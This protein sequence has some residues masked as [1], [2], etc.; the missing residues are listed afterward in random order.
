MSESQ[1]A[2]TTTTTTTTNHSTSHQSSKAI[3]G[4]LCAIENVWVSG[5]HSSF[6]HRNKD[7]ALIYFPKRGH[8]GRGIY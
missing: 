2:A 8:Y 1:L 3:P 4:G 6:K 5:V 7:L